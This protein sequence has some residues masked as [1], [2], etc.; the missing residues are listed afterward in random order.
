MLPSTLLSLISLIL[1]THAQSRI[2]L[3]LNSVTFS[4][5]ASSFSIP[6]QDELTVTVALCSASSPS[7]RFFVSNGTNS[8]IEGDPGPA[9]GEDIHEITLQDGFGNWTGAFPSGGVLAVEG[10][11]PGASFEVGVSN[12]SAFEAFDS[13]NL[14]MADLCC[15]S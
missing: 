3:S 8:A 2:P 5:S 9:G 10:L 14:W 6:G 12:D 1:S 7:P 13:G 11:P 15:L 4:N